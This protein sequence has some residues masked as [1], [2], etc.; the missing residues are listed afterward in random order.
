M[1]QKVSIKYVHDMVNDLLSKNNG[2]YI[3]KDELNRHAHAS[4][5]ELFD[6]L[7]G[8]TNRRLNQQTLVNYGRT[9]KTDERLKPFKKTSPVITVVDGEFTMPSDVAVI[10]SVLTTD[11]RAIKPIDED[12][13]GTIGD[14]PFRSPDEE[15]VYYLEGG[16]NEPTQLFGLADKVKVTYLR[17]PIKPKYETKETTITVGDRT[18]TREI[19]DEANSVDFDWDERQTL[20]LVTRILAKVGVSLKDGFVEQ[21][22]QVNKNNE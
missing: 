2:K 19:Y 9:Q 3:T 5:L 13:I 16:E 18:V 6:E 10:L 4:S 12:R 7:V 14:N 21:M 1:A 11:N 15:D 8:V 20:D 22:V 17:K